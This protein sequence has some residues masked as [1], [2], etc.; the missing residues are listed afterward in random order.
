L[1]E[2]TEEADA[3]TVTAIKLTGDEV[4]RLNDLATRRGE[5]VEKLTRLAVVDFLD[6]H[7]SDDW[8]TVLLAA[9]GLWAD[10]TDLPDFQELRAEV[11]RR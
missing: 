10:R 3:M 9:S 11:D 4:R 5:T 7:E 2:S 1:R 6:R 8:R